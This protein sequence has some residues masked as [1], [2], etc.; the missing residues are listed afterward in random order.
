MFA[1]AMFMSLCVDVMVMSSVL[2][3]PVVLGVSDG[4]MLKSV[5]DSMPSYGTAFLNWRCI[6]VLFLNVVYALRPLM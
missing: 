2:L 1:L 6:D 4:Y 3:V 5:G